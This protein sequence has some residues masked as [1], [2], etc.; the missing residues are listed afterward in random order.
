MLILLLKRIDKLLQICLVGVLLLGVEGGKVGRFVYDQLTEQMARADIAADGIGVDVAEIK[1]DVVENQINHLLRFVVAG[2]FGLER[3]L[4][5]GRNHLL[6][7]FRSHSLGY[8]SDKFKVG[9]DRNQKARGAVKIIGAV[10]VLIRVELRIWD[11]SE[12]GVHFPQIR[13][14]AEPGGHE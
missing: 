5:E 10:V 9:G 4:I 6:V 7:A 3:R 14:V 8:D 2:V 13:A 11:D 1:S 12:I